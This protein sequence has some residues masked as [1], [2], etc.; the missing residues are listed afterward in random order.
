[1]TSV[2]SRFLRATLYR[3]AVGMLAVAFFA[4]SWLVSIAFGPEASPISV[5]G[6][7]I[8]L[9]L[10]LE[11]TSFATTP[12]LKEQASPLVVTAKVDG[13]RCVT[14]P[15]LPGVRGVASIAGC[16]IHIQRPAWPVGAVVGS[17]KHHIFSG[18]FREG[19][20]EVVVGVTEHGAKL[21]LV[22]AS[23]LRVQPSHANVCQT[24]LAVL[25]YSPRHESLQRG[26]PFD[27]IATE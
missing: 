20:S 4:L 7:G 18:E 8:N 10:R 3:L 2:P 19:W 5:E 14:S 21:C 27:A 17:N 24:T 9:P 23:A 11:G 16:R 1:M 6:L 15:Q 26:A 22:S 13:E 25:S 12:P